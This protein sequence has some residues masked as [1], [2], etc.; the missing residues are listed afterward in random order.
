MSPPTQKN[1]GVGSPRNTVLVVVPILL[2]LITFLFWY[3]TW[4]G[5]A[6]S[7]QEM[8]NYLVDTSVPHKTQHALS[9]LS[10]RMA[11]GDPTAKRWYPQL[12]A[13]AESREPQIRLEAAW[14]MG[15][16]NHSEE[17]HQALNKL[18]HDAEPMVRRNAALALV[19]FGDGAGEP[20]LRSML[21]PFT[22]VSPCPGTLKFRL[23]E[24][25]AV[26]DGTILARVRPQG[27]DKQSDVVSPVGGNIKRLLVKDGA[28]VAEGEAL[29]LITP[30]E[31]QVWESLRALYLV[32]QPQ[33]LVDVERFAQPLPNMSDR[34]RQQAAATAQA[35]RQRAGKAKG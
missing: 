12:L 30:D 3:Q 5:R 8:G 18:I 29:A 32:G 11:R 14:A 21:E 28:C 27:S 6:L 9:Q 16:D 13:L 33:D 20:E 34:V 19:R 17:F 35:I 31:G 7:D 22:L 24:Q 10:E 4:F 25:D 23:K 2:V 1:L 15:Q 26:R